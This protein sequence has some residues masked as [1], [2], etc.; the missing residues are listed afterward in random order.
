MDFSALAA[1]MNTKRPKTIQN[2]DLA[3]G[4]A[5][6][7]RV[8]NGEDPQDGMQPGQPDSLD[9]AKA[10]LI[11][12]LQ[13]NGPIQGGAFPGQMATGDEMSGQVAQMQHANMQ[14]AANDPTT[15][16]RL[17]ATHS[18][19]EKWKAKQEADQLARLQAA[20]PRQQ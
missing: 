5:N 2:E 20:V 16:A 11:A 15:M 6:L 4:I 19:I 18:A 8:T 9:G 3:T 10:P 7:K 13:S 14:Q 12:D 1:A 17:A